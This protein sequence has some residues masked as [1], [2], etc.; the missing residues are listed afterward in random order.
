MPM[1]IQMQHGIAKKSSI[2]P[3]TTSAVAEASELGS[4]RHSQ[5]PAGGQQI[6]ALLLASAHVVSWQ[7]LSHEV[8][9]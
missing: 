6:Q 1:H 3:T 8:H 2:E 5:Y 4:A 9:S 7:V